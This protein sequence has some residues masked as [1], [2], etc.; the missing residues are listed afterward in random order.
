MRASTNASPASLTARVSQVANLRV[1]ASRAVG[2]RAFPCATPAGTFRGVRWSID[3]SDAPSGCRRSTNAI[4]PSS[5]A[6]PHSTGRV[7]S[8]RGPGRPLARLLPSRALLHRCP[9]ADP[10]TPRCR[11]S[12]A[13]FPHRRSS[14][15]R[16]A[17]Q[18]PGVSDDGFVTPIRVPE[19]VDGPRTPTRVVVLTRSPVAGEPGVG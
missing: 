1:R 13:T 11:C 9:L 3:Q 6:Q 8:R 2:R 7:T 16:V 12:S 4:D 15:A 18:P 5:Q 19:M 10:I 17:F 14:G